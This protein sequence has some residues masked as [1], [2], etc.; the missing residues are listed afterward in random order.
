MHYLKLNYLQY[1]HTRLSSNAVWRTSTRANGLKDWNRVTSCEDVDT[2]KYS[3]LM[4][5]A[6]KECAPIKTIISLN[7]KSTQCTNIAFIHSFIHAFVWSEHVTNPLKMRSLQMHN[8]RMLRSIRINNHYLSK[9][10]KCSI[11]LSLS[12]SIFSFLIYPLT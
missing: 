10:G 8:P 7:Y 4:E 12:I 1:K 2:H 9:M 3:T 5:E 6:I 11:F